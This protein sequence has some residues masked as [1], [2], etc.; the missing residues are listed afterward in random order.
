MVDHGQVEQREVLAQ[1][2][3]AQLVRRLEGPLTGVVEVAAEGGRVR[4]REVDGD[5]A[6]ERH[7]VMVTVVPS[8]TIDTSSNSLINRRAPGSPRPRPSPVA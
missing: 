1:G 5:V 4:R 6:H 8:P 7:L 2:R 3:A